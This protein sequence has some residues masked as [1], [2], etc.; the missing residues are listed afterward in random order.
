MLKRTTNIKEIMEIDKE[1]FD[2][3]KYTKQMYHDMLPT[4]E[5]Y[6]IYEDINSINTIVG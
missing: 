1:C 6:L 5:F 3:S 4:S 2:N